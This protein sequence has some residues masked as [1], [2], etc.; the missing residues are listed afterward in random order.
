MNESK[1]SVRYA[2]ALYDLVKEDNAMDALRQDME[3][4]SLCI[5]DISELQYI[6]HSPVIRVSEKKRIFAEIFKTSFNPLTI[7]FINLVLEHRREEYLAGI[8][9]YFL[10]LLKTDLGI[11]SAELVTARPLDDK[12]RQS[13]IQ[14]IARKFKARVELSE[15]VDESLI[16]GF[17]LRVGDQQI[18]ASIS[19]KLKRIREELTDSQLC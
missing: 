3:L 1:I 11:R 8:S 19:N 4:L 9:R 5:R 2:R 15:E 14:F 6:I 18:D 17:V 7:K 10:D 16:G 12:L 13:V